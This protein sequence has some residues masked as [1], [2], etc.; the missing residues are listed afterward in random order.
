[1]KGLF[2]SSAIGVG[3]C[4]RG[5][6]PGVAGRDGVGPRSKH[7][8]RRPKGWKTEHALHAAAVT[9]YKRVSSKYV[10]RSLHYLLPSLRSSVHHVQRHK[11]GWKEALCPSSRAVHPNRPPLRGIRR[12]AWPHSAP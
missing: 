5:Y 4:R 2:E 7:D 3:E 9:L 6:E 12:Q 10:D 1:M 11:Q 8:G